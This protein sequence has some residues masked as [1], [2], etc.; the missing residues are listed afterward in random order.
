MNE[1]EIYLLITVILSYFG[2]WKLF[3]LLRTI[4]A[5]IGILLLLKRHGLIII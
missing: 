3:F 5:V 1:I 4:F 2:E